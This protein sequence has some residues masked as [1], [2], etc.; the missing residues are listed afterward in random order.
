MRVITFITQKGGA[1]KTTLAINCAVLAGQKKKKAL[2]LD[3]DPQ[4]SS[5]AWF[6]DREAES[7]LLVAA[8]AWR[9]PEALA[10][11]KAGGFDYVLIDTPGRD[12]P[13]TNAAIGA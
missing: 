6:Q 1:G 8:T 2:I 4:A 7:P 3:L 13:S 12:E 11:A 10:T 5:E 9:L